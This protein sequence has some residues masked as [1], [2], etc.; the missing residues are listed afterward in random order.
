MKIPTG[1]YGGRMMYLWESDI[2]E[3]V[4]FKP[5]EIRGKKGR[6]KMK[7]A[8]AAI[9]IPNMDADNFEKIC[10]EKGLQ[11]VYVEVPPH[12]RLGDL[13]ELVEKIDGIWDCNDMV[14]KPDDH[15]CN[16]PED[17][18]GCKWAQTKDCIQ[19]MVENAPT[20]IEADRGDTQ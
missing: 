20:I 4:L 15:C 7:K 2:Q 19:R 1:E 16:V 18:K 12:G 3:S 5:I 6:K 8:N 11:F 17:C 9:Y 14:F 13:D 10:N